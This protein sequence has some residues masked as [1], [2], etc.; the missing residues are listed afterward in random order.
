[1]EDSLYQF[2]HSSYVVH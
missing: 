1:M 2:D